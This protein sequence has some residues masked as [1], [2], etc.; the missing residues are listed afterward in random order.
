MGQTVVVANVALAS[1]TRLVTTARVSMLRPVPATVRVATKVAEIVIVTQH[2]NPRATAVPMFVIIVLWSFVTVLQA[3]QTKNVAV[4]GAVELA[5]CV[6]R[7]HRCVWKAP[8]SQQ[9][10]VNPNVQPFVERPT[11]LSVLCYVATCLG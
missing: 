2:A 7:P 4:M 5:E 11:P 3:V 1:L 8:A 9:M 10:P 6:L